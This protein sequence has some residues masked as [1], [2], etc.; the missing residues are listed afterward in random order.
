MFTLVNKMNCT[1]IKA[2]LSHYLDG[3]LSPRLQALMEKHLE[4]CPACNV[5]LMRLERA[6]DLVASLPVETA[7]PDLHLQVKRELA[8]LGTMQQRPGLLE[9][10]SGFRHGR[11]APVFAAGLVLVLAVS[12]WINVAGNREGPQ[13]MPG[14]QIIEDATSASGQELTAVCLNN[15]QYYSV[16]LAGLPFSAEYVTEPVVFEQG[17]N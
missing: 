8:L 17:Q 9:W 4:E 2:L 5:E 12:L 11:F 15:H 16:D 6:V 1:E 7:R 3:E 10:I 13:I 14:G